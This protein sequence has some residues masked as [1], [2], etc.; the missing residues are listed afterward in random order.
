[1]EPV[2]VR[3]FEG[4][5]LLLTTAVFLL[6]RTPFTLYIGLVY[7]LTIYASERKAVPREPGL[8]FQTILGVLLILISPVFLAIRLGEYPSPSTF[9]T[10]LLTGLQL[11]FFRVRG[12]EIPLTV[13]AGGVGI[14]LSSKTDLIRRVIDV[15]S[16]FFVDVTSVLVKGLVVLSGIPIQ[17]NGNIAVV[18]NVLVII[19]SGCS[20]FDAFVIYTLASLLL[21]YMRRSSRWEALLLIFGAVGIV[22]LNALRIFLLLII[23]YYTGI[24][25]LELFHSHLGDLMFVAYV[26]LYWWWV[27]R[28]SERKMGSAPPEEQHRSEGN[29]KGN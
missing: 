21:I 28:K 19:G 20:G 13:A 23:G 18:R 12:L 9:L 27:T 7:A 24:S 8:D 14:A 25:F 17:I 22:P 5:V 29:T 15:T 4:F 1:M 6:Y 3:A 2:K 16:G 10:L 11:V 26:F